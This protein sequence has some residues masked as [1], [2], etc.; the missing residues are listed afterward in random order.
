ML[1]ENGANV[2]SLDQNKDTALSYAS[3]KGAE[4]EVNCYFDTN[5]VKFNFSGFDGIVEKL[6]QKGANINVSNK[7]G[8]TALNM[9][10]SAGKF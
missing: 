2:N 1:I 9:A 4:I 6:I 7:W 3:E 10:T 5:S 8:N